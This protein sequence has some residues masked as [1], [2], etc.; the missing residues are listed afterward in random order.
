MSKRLYRFT[1]IQRLFHVLLVLSFLIQAA[2]GLGRMYMETPWGQALCLMFG[3]Y[4]RAG[5]VHRVIGLFMLV[6]F[7]VHLIYLMCCIQWRQFPGCLMGPDSMVPAPRDLGHFFQHVGWFF[8][9][10][11]EPP[12]DRWGYWEKFD[13]WAV[14]WGMVIM[15]SSGL[16]VAYPLFTSRFMPGWGLNVAFWVHRLEALLAMGHVFMI[17]FFIGHLRPRHFPMDRSI[18]QGSARLDTVARER[19]AWLAR[20]K[21]DGKFRERLTGDVPRTRKAIYL[22]FGFAAM[23]VGIY[24]LLGALFHATRITW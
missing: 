2:S 1:P 11:P 8:G 22:V 14:F 10:C 7:A 19:P 3:G 23:A 16:M 12:L 21:A 20:L 24:L 13:Y 17:H 4:G 5:E 18:F 15:G 6:L 9:R